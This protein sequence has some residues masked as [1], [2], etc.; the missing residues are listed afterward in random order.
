MF[1]TLNRNWPLVAVFA[2][3][4]WIGA[5]TAVVTE[6]GQLPAHARG[7]A[8]QTFGLALLGGF[9]F[10]IA[11]FAVHVA[12]PKLL[13]RDP[14]KQARNVIVAVPAALAF[15]AVLAV[16]GVPEYARIGAALGVIPVG[17]AFRIWFERSD[18]ARR[19]WPPPNGASDQ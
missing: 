16:T 5:L 1:E 11:I 9:A 4:L 15:V 2:A 19:R 13:T 14:R 12:V 18:Y 17:I 6:I 8:W 3:L 7:D 10:T